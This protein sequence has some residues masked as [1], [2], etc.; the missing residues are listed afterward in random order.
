MINMS[1]IDEN[2][3]VGIELATS[4]LRL[5]GRA[6]IA[7]MDFF[8]DSDKDDRKQHYQELDNKQG[9]QKLKDLFTKHDNTSVESLGENLSKDE[10]TFIAKELKSMGVDFSVRKIGKDNYSLFFAGKDSEAIEKGMKNAIEKFAKR[11]QTKEKIKE[12]LKGNKR[13]PYD[14]INPNQKQSNTNEKDV[15]ENYNSN[16]KKKTS[17]KNETKEQSNKVPKFNMNSLQKQHIE[18]KDK[19]KQEKVRTNTNVKVPKRSL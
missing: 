7:I 11:E 6:I 4:T 1:S 13:K 2:A 10:Q 12:N 19:Q 8:L 3:Q 14:N 15:N 9:K 5:S 17:T 16:Q 18:K